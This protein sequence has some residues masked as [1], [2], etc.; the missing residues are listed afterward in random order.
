MTSR[1]KTSPDQ[2]NSKGNYQGKANDS[3]DCS[4]DAVFSC[5]LTTKLSGA[6]GAPRKAAID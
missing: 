5:H 4:P 2:T 6:D 1:L 3:R